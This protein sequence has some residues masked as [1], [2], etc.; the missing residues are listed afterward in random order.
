MDQQPAGEIGADVEEGSRSV[1]KEKK[2]KVG[3]ESN[4]EGNVE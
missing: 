3:F 2:R 1:G 4:Q